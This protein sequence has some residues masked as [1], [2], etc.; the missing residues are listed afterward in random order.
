MQIKMCIRA[1]NYDDLIVHIIQQIWSAYI[2]T[3]NAMQECVHMYVYMCVHVCVWNKKDNT[4]DTCVCVCVCV[5]ACDKKCK[6][7]NTYMC[8]FMHELQ[9]WQQKQY[10]IHTY[11][12]TYTHIERSQILTINFIIFQSVVS[13]RNSTHFTHHCLCQSRNSFSKRT[14][15]ER[16]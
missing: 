13:I 16:L 10:N 14:L 12:H 4:S 5:C 9:E 2:C 3:R 1:A 7:D 15:I 6:K 8:V 11:T